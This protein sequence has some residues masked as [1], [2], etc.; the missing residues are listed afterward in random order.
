MSPAIPK[1]KPILSAVLINWTLVLVF[2]CCTAPI[3]DCAKVSLQRQYEH[4]R[5]Y[6]LA[7]KEINMK[8]STPKVSEVCV[9][10]EINDYFPA[11]L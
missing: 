8:W 1:L 2:K 9:G 11:E 7:K 10:M 5:P 3:K 6:L 4:A